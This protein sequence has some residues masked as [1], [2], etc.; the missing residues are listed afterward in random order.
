[1]NLVLMGLPGAGKGTQADKIVD[2]YGVPH[3]STGDMFRLAMKEGTELGLKAKS[4]I[5]KGELVPDEVTIGIVRERLSMKDCE[6]GFLLDGFPRT[7]AQAEALEVILADLGKK[8]DYVIN[9]DVDQSILM[10]RLT[11]RRICKNC[12]ATY[13][14]VFNPPAEAGVCDRCNGE[15]Y[16]RADDNAETVQ[17][18]LDVNVK[19]TQP[20]LD[21]Y[22][23]KGYLK[24][25]NGQQHIDQVFSNLDE[26]LKG[27][28]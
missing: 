24:N 4:F 8:I 14:L 15:L 12:G 25:I 5:D 10:E 6:Q 9:I 7:V 2:K 13:H 17:N 16:Q 3:I 23:E 20:L 27:L 18:R 11:G 19:Q 22:N 26:L 21:Y 1:M 28:K